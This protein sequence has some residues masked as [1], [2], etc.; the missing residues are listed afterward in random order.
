MCARSCRSR[1]AKLLRH[2][3][4]GP[5]SAMTGGY[6]IRYRDGLFPNLTL[7]LIWFSFFLFPLTL[8]YMLFALQPESAV[9]PVYWTLYVIVVGTFFTALKVTNFRLHRIF[10]KEEKQKQKRQAKVEKLKREKEAREKESGTTQLLVEG[11]PDRREVRLYI[12]IYIRIYLP[13]YQFPN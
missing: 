13:C 7:S 5:L 12:Y 1:V 11:G 2:L 4:F 10:D 9:S 8:Y 6:I 3:Y